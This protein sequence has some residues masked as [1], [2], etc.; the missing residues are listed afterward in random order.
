MNVTAAPLGE[1]TARIALRNRVLAAAAAT[2]SMT[3]RQGQRIAVV[4]TLASVGV[5]L[6][7]FELAGGLAPPRDRPLF[8]TVRLADGWALFSAILTWLVIGRGRST[9][10]RPPPAIAAATFACPLLLMSWTQQFGDLSLAASSGG[11]WSCFLLTMLVAAVPL[12]SFL[13]LRRGVEPQNPGTLGAAMGAMCGSWASVLG[14]LHCP[15]VA[16]EHVLV[17]HVAPL[18]LLTMLGMLMGPSA[19]GPR[20][21]AP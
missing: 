10:A 8:M 21:T 11:P 18:V 6:A 1:A 13:V 4:L 3:R 16:S 15:I 14:L 20:P 9:L 5:A 7:L 17:G 2:P 12:A 19:L